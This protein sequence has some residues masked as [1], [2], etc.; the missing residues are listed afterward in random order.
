MRQWCITRQRGSA[1]WPPPTWPST[2]CIARQVVS[3]SSLVSYSARSCRRQGNVLFWLA[4]NWDEVCMS[5]CLCA[6]VIV[7]AE[8]QPSLSEGACADRMLTPWSAGVLTISSCMQ[9]RL[10]EEYE[11]CQH[12]L[13]PATRKPLIAAVEAQL[14]E[15]HIGAVLEKG[16]H[17]NQH[18]RLAHDHA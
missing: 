6:W 13:D 2:C 10:A 9:R 16:A 4:G 12:Y 5:R 15:R 8:P 3:C 14:L 17:S 11:R 18:H 1:T 7:A